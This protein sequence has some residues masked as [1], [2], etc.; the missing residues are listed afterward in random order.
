VDT[1]DALE[2]LHHGNQG[3]IVHCDLKPS[4]ILLD[5]NM[6]A[7]IGDFGLARFRLDSAAALSTH[8]IS[9]SAAIMG[10]IGYIAPECATGGAVSSAGD[11]YSFG[12]VLLEIFLRRRPTDD[13]FNGGMNITK[14]VEMNFPDMIPQII[15]SELLEEQQDLSHETA[16]AMKEKS[17]ECLLSVLNIGL[18][19]TKTSPNERTSMHEV[20]ARLHE[21][22]KAYAREN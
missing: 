8:S 11:V 13:M 2:Y 4:N 17:L 14:F 21:I 1:A 5:D 12:I 18:L 9:T 20:A 15:D 16:L 10:T 6:T 19:C 22:K 3:T 7:H